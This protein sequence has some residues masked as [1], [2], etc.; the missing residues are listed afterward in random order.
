[1]QLYTALVFDGPNLVSQIKSGLADLLKKDRF[2]SIAEA[3]GTAHDRAPA[4]PLEAR[5][6][7]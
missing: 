5:L 2:G 3:V 7:V 6:A 4:P 1:M